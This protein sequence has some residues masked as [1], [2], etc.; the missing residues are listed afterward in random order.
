MAR[1]LLYV[2]CSYVVK[3]DCVFSEFLKVVIAHNVYL[4]HVI[5][6]V[7]LVG[8]KRKDQKYQYILINMQNIYSVLYYMIRLWLKIKR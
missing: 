4:S 6:T 5:H 7:L 8:G 2:R 1:L 3:L